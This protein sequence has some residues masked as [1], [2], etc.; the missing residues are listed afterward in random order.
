MKSDRSKG[1]GPLFS[2]EDMDPDRRSSR[3][4]SPA[5]SCVS[6]KSDRSKGQ[7]PLFSGEDM[8]PDRSIQQGQQRARQT[9]TEDLA[10]IFQRLEQ[11][12]ITFMKKE[13]KRLRK[14]LS[15]DYPECPSVEE[16]EEENEGQRGARDGAL[17]IAVHI[18]REMSQ[19]TLAEQLEKHGLFPRCQQELKHRLS[20]KF[21]SVFEGIPR[22]GESA[23]LEK[24][25]TELYITEGECVEVSTEHEVRQIEI[26]SKAQVTKA[27]TP[28]KYTDIFKA[29][30]G[31]DK[32]IRTVMTKGVAGIG[33]TVS[34]QKFI[35]DWA[36]GK[37]NQDIHFLFPVPFREI[38]LM[39]EKEYTLMEFIHHFFSETRDLIFSID[40]KYN[41]AFI[42][43]GLDESRRP[44]DFQDNECIYNVS[45]PATVDVLLTNLIKGNLL[46]FVQ[47][48]ITS[49]PA[50]SSQI[51]PECVDQVTEVRGFTDP[52]K[53]E[54]FRK[55]INEQ[56]MASRI[57]THLKSSRSL[58]IMCHIPVFCWMAA[59]VLVSILTE[60]K[61][62]Q[63]PV[64]LTQMYIHF[65]IIHAKHIS[66]KYKDIWNQTTVLSL[67]RLAFQQLE[68]G[69]LI[70][71][72]EDL[73]ECGMDS[74]KAKEA[75]VYSGVCTQIFREE[76]G[77]YQQKV[78]CF[79]HL[80]IQEFLAALYV[81]LSFS[82]RNTPPSP[83][84]SQFQ[85]LLSAKEF[86]ELHQTAVD[87]ALGNEHGHLDLFLRFLLG[88]SLESNQKLLHDLLPQIGSSSRDTEKTIKY[89]KQKITEE[90]NPERCINLFH[91]LNEL[92][93]HSLVEE[94]RGYLHRGNR[95][96]KEL[97]LSQLS[98]LA[99]VMLVSDQDV[100]EFNLWDYG[101]NA[102]SDAGLL[103]MLPVVKISRTV[104]LENC[105][106]TKL[107]CSS[108]AS[109]LSSKP[110]SLRQ[111]YLNG[112]MQLGDSGVKLL[113]TGLE[114][115]NCRLETLK[116]NDCSITEESCAA[117]TSAL[118]SNPS[119]HLIKLHLSSNTLGDSGVK[120]LSDL[121]RNPDCKLQALKL[122]YCSITAEGCA[123]L[124]SGLTSNPSSH[125][126]ELTLDHNEVGDSG[127]KQ[128]SDLL[129]KPDCKL[130]ALRLRR[131]SITAEGCAALASALASNPSSHLSELHLDN[132]ELEAS[133]MQQ[134]SALVK[135][136]KSKRKSCE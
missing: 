97:S 83:Q 107:S 96:N 24:I 60:G 14:L 124:A 18:L 35:L 82:I 128:L 28:I 120:Q 92:N 44:L 63:I 108:L 132:N 8:D 31:K 91:C 98:A 87:L 68:K 99:F 32:Q 40:D 110:S 81:F 23:S 88:L 134:I 1:Q 77:L 37:A 69:N 89:I 50:A 59:T 53:E 126:V 114:H 127:A 95:H 34:V 117:L 105:N 72:E 10:A 103:R 11:H 116:L 80:S 22:Q 2:G 119:S 129:R 36:E 56:E 101:S 41:I 30:P 13:L 15:H 9:P 38:N 16:E 7:G 55:N 45:E 33:K 71:Y 46:P 5:P 66:Q 118:I 100:E 19:E 113:S 79:V 111:L 131:C 57:I 86:H 122:I 42:F 130:Q 67:A 112:N 29:L 109:A 12:I 3:P 102:R 106:L 74:N 51:P 104:K 70:F 4:K 125:L 133:A 25:Y 121:L 94:V 58:Y 73:R 43:D 90:R 47:V 136:P 17:S 93:D 135:D 123:A 54:Y 76:S 84:P 115:P 85:Q 49:R 62:D 20:K 48:W 6:M 52:Q 64:S 75:S 61:T 65:L 26:A 78:F 21:K 39:K 27:E